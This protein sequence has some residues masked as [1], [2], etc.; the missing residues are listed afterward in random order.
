MIEVTNATFAVPAVTDGVFMG[1]ADQGSGA[2]AAQFD[3]A[4]FQKCRAPITVNSS[5][6]L[7]L[8]MMNNMVLGGNSSSITLT[9]P[10]E[11]S[12]DFPVGSVIKIM[13]LSSNAILI[14]AAGGVTIRSQ[15]SLLS[16]N[17]TYSVAF[18]EKIGADLWVFYGD[19]N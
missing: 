16:V 6:S 1:A 17:T 9:V 18:L 10:A 8:A 4:N 5:Q 7:T 13:Q 3:T 2:Q 12:V 19:R 14:A 11:A 15:G